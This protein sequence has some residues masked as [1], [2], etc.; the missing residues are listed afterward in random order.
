M[1]RDRDSHVSEVIDRWQEAGVNFEKVRSITSRH[2][3]SRFSKLKGKI[4]F[5]GVMDQL[6]KQRILS[7]TENEAKR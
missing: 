1:L 6:G 4:H 3:L 2:S 5:G 7:A